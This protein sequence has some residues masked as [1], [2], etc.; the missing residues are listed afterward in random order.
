VYYTTPLHLQQALR[1]LGWDS[2]SLPETERAAQE[3]F[4]LPLWP[5]IP[6]DVQERVVET[7]RSAVGV[8]VR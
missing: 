2:G 4:S 8:G 5:G 1:F 7:V 3:N 6:V